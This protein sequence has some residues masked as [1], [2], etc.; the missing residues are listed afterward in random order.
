MYLSLFRNYGYI[1]QDGD[2]DLY[3]ERPVYRI[4]LCCDE[5]SESSSEILKILMKQAKFYDED[6][7][8]FIFTYSNESSM[9]LTAK[10]VG[11]Y[12]KSLNGVNV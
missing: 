2:D 8:I 11:E 4:V 10:K 1:T 3:I 12:L 7:K 6:N 5:I 9:L